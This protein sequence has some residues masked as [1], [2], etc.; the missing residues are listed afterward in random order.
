VWDDRSRV[1]G[2]Y[3]LEFV[4]NEVV[5]AFAGRRAAMAPAPAR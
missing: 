3:L 4:N 5:V 2:G 1:R